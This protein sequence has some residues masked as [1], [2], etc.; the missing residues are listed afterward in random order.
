MCILSI[1]ENYLRSCLEQ[2][3]SYFIHNFKKGLLFQISKEEPTNEKNREVKGLFKSSPAINDFRIRGRELIIKSKEQ[4][5]QLSGVIWY[6]LK[7]TLQALTILRALLYNSTIFNVLT[8]YS[9]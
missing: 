8:L 1:G 4:K 3:Y 7:I 9:C 6:R 5:V 2:I